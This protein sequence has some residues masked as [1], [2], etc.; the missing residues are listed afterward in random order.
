[1]RK[2]LLT[3]VVAFALSLALVGSAAAAGAATLAIA[4]SATLTDRALVVVPVV[5]SCPADSVFPSIYVTVTQAAGQTLHSGQSV[6]NIACDGTAH[7]YQVSIV[8]GPF[9]GGSAIVSGDLQFEP[10]DYSGIVDAPAGPQTIML[11]AK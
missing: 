7:T 1:M 3:G 10:A 4:P 9:H 8:G 2:A 5:A 11:A 6:T